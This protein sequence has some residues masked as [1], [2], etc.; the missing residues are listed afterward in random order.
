MN[1]VDNGVG[2]RQLGPA[3]AFP[4]K[5]AF[6][7]HALWNTGSRVLSIYLEI[8]TGCGIMAKD[9]RLPVDLARDRLGVR[10]DQEFG[11]IEATALFRLPWAVDS[12]SIELAWLDIAEQ[13]VPHMGC[14][15]AK[16]HA[17][18]LFAI[19]VKQAKINLGGAL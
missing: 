2:Q 5:L 12:I 9:G 3:I 6:D 4:V 10:I 17:A 18:G 7:H 8:V 1:F 14:P 19:R 11:G 16:R 15:L 13:A